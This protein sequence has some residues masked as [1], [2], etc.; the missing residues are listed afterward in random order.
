MTDLQKQTIK[1][2]VNIFETGR[3]AG[4]YSAVAV[5]PGDS[6]HLSYGRSQAALGSGTLLALLNEYCGRSDARF[7]NALHG[8]LDRVARKDFSLDH[9][10]AFRMTLMQ[11]GRDPAMQATQDDLFDRGFFI[12]ATTAALA[13]GVVSPLGQAVVYD[14]FIQGGWLGL[15]AQLPSVVSAGGET[16]WIPRYLAERRAWLES[17]PAPLPATVYRVDTFTRLIAANN[18]GLALP[19]DVHG[20]TIPANLPL[21]KAA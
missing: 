10:A 16:K 13:I 19:I 9:D 12:P 17:S 15:K 2:I 14:S 4:N 20:T 3:I 6:G 8:F 5:L 11:A 21:P 1:S 7:A 18:W